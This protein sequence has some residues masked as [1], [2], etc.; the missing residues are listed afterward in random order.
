MTAI[1]LTE[2]YGLQ[3]RD[4]RERTGVPN[5]DGARAALECFYYSFNQRSLAVFDAIW[6]EESLIQLNSPLGGILRGHEQV[7]ALYRGIFEGPVQVW[8]EFSDIVQYA[9][10]EM[11]VFAGREQ[12]EFT[13]GDK[14]VALSI[15][16][17]RAFQYFGEQLG[18]RQVHHHGSID[19]PE[20][21]AT[22]QAAVQ[23]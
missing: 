3:A 17:S 18:W 1:H 7:R 8:V 13:R 15:R 2:S 16:T 9:S 22:Y 21:L 5:V 23:R 19:S 20:A 6:A 10:A 4:L 14:T 11:V 12:G